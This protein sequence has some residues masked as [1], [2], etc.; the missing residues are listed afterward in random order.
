MKPGPLFVYKGPIPH[1]EIKSISITHAKTK[2]ISIHR[3]TPSDLSFIR[4]TGQF[5]PLTQKPS[6]SITA[7]KTSQF[8]RHIVNFDPPHKK[9]VN[10]DATTKKKSNS[11]PQT[12]TLISTPPL[13]SCHFDPRSK[14][15]SISMPP[16]K[17]QVNFDP[18]AELKSSQSPTLK[19]SQFGRPTQKSSEIRFCTQTLG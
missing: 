17:N 8:A 10:F 18:D 13:K 19:Q 1:T 6:Q 7:L 9:Q 2:S 12:K 5:R 11:T 3:L 4:K 14:L 15:K 16:L